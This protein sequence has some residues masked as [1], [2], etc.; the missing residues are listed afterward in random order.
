LDD[1][2][3]N[4]PDKKPMWDVLGGKERTSLSQPGV[5]AECDDVKEVERFDWPNPDYID[6]QIILEKVEQAKAEGLAVFGGMKL[7]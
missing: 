5:F 2:A 7:C 4:H 6:F 1:A 3:W